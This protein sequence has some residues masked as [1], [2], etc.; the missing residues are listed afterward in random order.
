[1]IYQSVQ[2]LIYVLNE[3]E[4][5]SE[6]LQLLLSEPAALTDDQRAEI[7]G[8]LA[9]YQWLNEKC[10]VKELLDIRKKFECILKEYSK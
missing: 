1:M 3:I 6:R 7:G 8:L 5:F 10:T 9:R 2:E 4:E